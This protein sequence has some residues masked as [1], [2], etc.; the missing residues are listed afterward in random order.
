MKRAIKYEGIIPTKKNKQGK[1]ENIT[2]K[3]IIE[4][5]A[6][7]QENRSNK[8]PF[9]VIVEGKSPGDDSKVSLSIIKPFAEAGATWWI[10]SD[11]TTNNLEQLFK[12]IKQGPPSF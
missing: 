10:E 5:K 9:D 11:W 4:I 6:Y 2:P 8:A 7:I 1:F 3:H 12:R